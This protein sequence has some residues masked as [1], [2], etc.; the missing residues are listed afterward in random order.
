MGANV[1]LGKCKTSTMGL[2][3]F[4]DPNTGDLPVQIQADQGPNRPAIPKALRRPVNG[5]KDVANQP[6]PHV[7]S[8]DGGIGL[9]FLKSISTWHD[10]RHFVVCLGCDICH[11]TRCV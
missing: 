11:N 10:R 3:V 2:E 7:G 8:L 5:P 9:T 1:T 4:E 6:I